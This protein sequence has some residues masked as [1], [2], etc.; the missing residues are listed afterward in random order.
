MV[1]YC[2]CLG[3]ELVPSM[4]L[5]PPPPAPLWLGMVGPCGWG[6]LVW[7]QVGIT[8]LL[9]WH[10]SQ[11]AGLGQARW[12]VVWLGRAR[13]EEHTSKGGRMC[14][15]VCAYRYIYIYTYCLT[16]LYW[17][18]CLH[19]LTPSSPCG[20]IPFGPACPLDGNFVQELWPALAFSSRGGAVS[21]SVTG[22]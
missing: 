6:W 7:Y 21:L 9:V 1:S 20:R 4:F 10:F 8:C 15:C 19:T 3:L 5:T 12:Q 16:T 14:V 13:G 22:V 18:H 2:F 17:Q 11:Q